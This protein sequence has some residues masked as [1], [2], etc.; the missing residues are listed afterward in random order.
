MKKIAIYLLSVSV[1]VSL[2]MGC[3]SNKLGNDASMELDIYG[4]SGEYEMEIDKQYSIVRG[5]KVIPLPEDNPTEADF[6]VSMNI[7][8]NVTT[9]VLLS[10]RAK[11][12]HK[13]IIH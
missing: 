2:F 10:G 8:T 12:L 7:D 3:D 13:P 4:S 5:D 9:I 11:V 6:N 1:L